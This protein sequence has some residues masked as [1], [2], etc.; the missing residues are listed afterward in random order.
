MTR[1]WYWKLY[2]LVMAVLTLTF[3]GWGLMFFLSEE[4]TA[5]EDIAQ[6]AALPMY[7][8]QLVG[9]FGFVYGR[10]IG[11]ARV[12]K[13]AFAATILDL[14]WTGYTLETD[15]VSFASV[16]V[17]VLTIMVSVSVAIFLPLLAAL[18]LYAFRSDDVW[19]KTCYPA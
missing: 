17:T 8:V 11:S 15:L 1:R 2:L 9:F 10:R 12:W 7:L 14:L 19:A 13:L 4:T 6:W 3:A 16:G 5:I 18:Y